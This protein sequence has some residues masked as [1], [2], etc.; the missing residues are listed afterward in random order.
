MKSTKKGRVENYLNE[1]MESD[2]FAI[3]DL[4][5]L[6]V[7]ELLKVPE[8][9]GIG[10]ITISTVLAE[11]KSKYEED[12]FSEIDEELMTD[13]GVS[14]HPRLS[15]V[16]GDEAFSSEE[17]AFLRK[18]IQE[19]ADTQNT[20][21]IELKLALKNAGIDYMMILKDYRTQKE[22]ELKEWEKGSGY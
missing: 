22:L 3:E 12:F 15:S 4:L 2:S 7:D 19:K 8:L 11:F 20:E 9:K 16:S 1:L 18:M 5:A 14:H 13:V 10:K 21:L 17:I 6:T